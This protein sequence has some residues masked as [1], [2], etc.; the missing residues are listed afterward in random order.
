[1]AQSE[2]EPRPAGLLSFNPGI[3]GR[4]RF[5][6]PRGAWE[7]VFS[8]PLSQLAP[9]IPEGA[10]GSRGPGHAPPPLAPSNL[11]LHSAFSLHS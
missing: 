11:E 2:Y 5:C 3:L 7:V 6:W 4:E 10:V 9:S 8:W 1:M